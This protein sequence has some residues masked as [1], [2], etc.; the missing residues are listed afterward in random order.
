MAFVNIMKAA[1]FPRVIAVYA[2]QAQFLDAAEREANTN[3]VWA[4]RPGGTRG[5][6][7]RIKV[8][9]A[10]IT[11]VRPMNSGGHIR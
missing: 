6:V 8:N 11:G 7:A 4:K 3:G 10:A 5:G 2:K 9:S 1:R